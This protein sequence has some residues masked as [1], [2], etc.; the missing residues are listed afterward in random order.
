M[1]IPAASKGE[2]EERYGERAGLW[3]AI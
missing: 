3:T 2:G 1:A